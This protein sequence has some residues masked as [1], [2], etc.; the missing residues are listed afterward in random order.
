[1]P[2][3]VSM[4]I[5]SSGTSSWLKACTRP[6][7]SAGLSSVMW[8]LPDAAGTTHMPAGPLISVSRNSQRPANTSARVN[9]G[10]RPSSTSMLARPRSV[11]SSRVRCPALLSASARLTDTL[12]L[13]TPPFPL[14][15]AMTRTGFAAWP[16]AA[17]GSGRDMTVLGD[18]GV[19]GSTTQ[20]L[21]LQHQARGAGG[22]QVAGHLLSAGGVGQPQAVADQGRHRRAQA[23]GLV[24]L[25]QHHAF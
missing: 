3:A 1:M 24:G 12:V 11:S 25:G 22:L 16:A 21:Q 14:A 4:T 10:D 17:M 8:R 19:I 18:K 13:P 6:T 15:T 7:C 2:A 23:P 20:F 9:F 5:A